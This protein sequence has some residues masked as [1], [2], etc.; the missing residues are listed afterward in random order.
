MIR[1]SKEQPPLTSGKRKVTEASIIQGFNFSGMSISFSSQDQCQVCILRAASSVEFQFWCGK[2]LKRQLQVESLPTV[3]A[4]AG[5]GTEFSQEMWAPKQRAPQGRHDRNSWDV[6]DVD[7]ETMGFSSIFWVQQTRNIKSHDNL[8]LLG[9][10]TNLL[11][12]PQ[13]FPIFNWLVVRRGMMVFHD[14]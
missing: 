8:R 14:L 7:V 11:N 12:S 10:S 3:S 4:E 5:D 13:G 2:P 1:V 9:R 6:W